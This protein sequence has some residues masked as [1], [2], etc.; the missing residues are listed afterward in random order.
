MQRVELAGFGATMTSM[1]CLRK[2]YGKCRKYTDYPLQSVVAD[3]FGQMF[4][5]VVRGREEAD[6]KLSEDFSFC[7]RW[8]EMGG[9]TVAYLR[10][11]VV[12]HCGAKA[13]SSGELSRVGPW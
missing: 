7:K 9:R 13:Y 3:M 8:N 6:E 1:A 2:M 10:A 4:S 5:E 11:G 12:W